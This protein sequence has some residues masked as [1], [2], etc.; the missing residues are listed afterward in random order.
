MRKLAFII[1]AFG[2]LAFTAPAVAADT[3]RGA[4]Q[5]QHSPAAKTQQADE[6]S[7]SRRHRHYRHHRH[8]HR[9]HVYRH[10]HWQGHR[11]WNRCRT[12]W[13]PYRGGYVRVCR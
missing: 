13:N 8:H 3:S 5:T 7:S 2:A 4:A 6:F 11:G 12:V 1:A 9:S 10:R